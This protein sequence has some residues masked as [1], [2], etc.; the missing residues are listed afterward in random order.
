MYFFSRKW[1]EAAKIDII[2]TK[3][4]HETVKNTVKVGGN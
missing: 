2:Y 3:I 4:S 1:D